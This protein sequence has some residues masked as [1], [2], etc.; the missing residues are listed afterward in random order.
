M[1][2]KETKL[3]KA[4]EIYREVHLQNVQD[5]RKEF[6]KRL[7]AWHIEKYGVAAK[8]KL[9]PSY[10]QMLNMEADSKSGGVYHHHKNMHVKP[11]VVEQPLTI[12]EVALEEVA[13]AVQ[14]PIQ[15]VKADE[16]EM[17]WKVVIGEMEHHFATRDEAR[18]YKKDMGGKIE[19]IA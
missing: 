9:A 5:P 15:E 13:A 10:Y 1:A 16:V 4:R 14:E 7:E 11:T 6:I 19:K 8:E 3:S 12:V 17:K 2:K 18:Q